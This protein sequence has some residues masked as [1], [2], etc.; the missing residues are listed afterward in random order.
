[1]A[2]EEIARKLNGRAGS[3][4]DCVDLRRFNGCRFGARMGFDAEN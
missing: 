4:S 1:M 3:L 2:S